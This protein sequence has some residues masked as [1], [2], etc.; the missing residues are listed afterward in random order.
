MKKVIV[1]IS[2]IL[3][4][5]AVFFL[6]REFENQSL[7]FHAVHGYIIPDARAVKIASFGFSNFASD[8]FTIQAV[9]SLY[10]KDKLDARFWEESVKSFKEL[11]RGREYH[12][13]EVKLDVVSFARY[14]YIAS[15]LDPFDVERIELFVLLMDWMIDF[16]DG[17]I[18]ILEYT[19]RKNT[20]DWRLPY[21]LALNYL[22]HKGDKQRALCWLKEASLRP[23]ALSIIKSL[24]ID[25]ASEGE[26]RENILSAMSG[27]R[28]VVRDE[29][30]KKG[31]DE[32]IQ[33]F[34]KG[35]II[36]RVDW[37]RVRERIKELREEAREEGHHHDEGD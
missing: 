23:G 22:I 6:E 5:A 4:S 37:E 20:S 35:G 27:L 33:Y 13:H 25:V 12:S 19:A 9:N 18:P 30:V 17:S 3:L 31:I 11:L 36:K 14:A 16:P 26:S 15:Y 24:M 34:R 2:C 10:V 29:E 28:E 1:W 8:I 21:Y 32:R 7:K